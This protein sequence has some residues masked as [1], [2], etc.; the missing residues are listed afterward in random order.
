MNNNIETLEWTISKYFMSLMFSMFLI[1]LLFLMFL[2][3]L[4]F[5]NVLNRYCQAPVQTTSRSCPGHS[6]AMFRSCTGHLNTSSISNLK[7]WTWSWLYNCNATHHHHHHQETFLSEIT[8]ISL[9]EVKL[10]HKGRY[11]ETSEDA[12]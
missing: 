8:Q 3:I 10:K 5:S 11:R 2:N 4:N 6:Q 12:H 9:Q 1:L 7:V